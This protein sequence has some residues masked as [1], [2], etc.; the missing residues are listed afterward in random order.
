MSE[1]LKKVKIYT[2]GACKGNPGPGGWGA[3]LIYKGVIRET[4]GGQ[5]QAT[6]NQMELMA[7]IKALERLKEKCQVEIFSDSTYVVDAFQKGWLEKWKRS[8]YQRRGRDIPNKKLWI[9]LDELV[10]QHV[11]KFRWVKGHENNK[12]NNR[13]DEMAVAESLRFN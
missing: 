10:A 5:E 4:S 3:I 9:Q 11:V 13:C 6:N 2:D 7:V 8:S 12:F 1:E